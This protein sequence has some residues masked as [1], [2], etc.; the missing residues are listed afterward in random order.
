MTMHTIR[1]ETIHISGFTTANRKLEDGETSSH[2]ERSKPDYQSDVRLLVEGAKAIGFG[3]VAT[4]D[5]LHY[6]QGPGLPTKAGAHMAAYGLAG[7]IDNHGGSA[8]ELAEADAK[9][10]T[11][12]AKIGDLLELDGRCY[13]IEWAGYGSYQD[14]HNLK[15]VP[16]FTILS[17]PHTGDAGVTYFLVREPDGTEQIKFAEEL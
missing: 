10:L 9:G 16:A 11:I 6:N 14:K 5:D 8:R 13:R 1:R 15:L 17:G 2:V 3:L 12:R 4:D 7:V